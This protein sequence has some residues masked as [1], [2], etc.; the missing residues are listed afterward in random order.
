MKHIKTLETAGLLRVEVVGRERIN[1]LNVV[2]LQHVYERW[3][4]PYETFWASKLYRLS[5]AAEQRDNKERKS[6]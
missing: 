2:P 4:K 3:L 1:H 6:S 5:E